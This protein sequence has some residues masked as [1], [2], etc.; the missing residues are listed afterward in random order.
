MELNLIDILILLIL[1]FI[2]LV[3][4]YNFVS[5]IQEFFLKVITN[6]IYVLSIIFQIVLVL[7]I[8]IFIWNNIKIFIPVEY[9]NKVE[10]TIETSF[11]YSFFE[12]LFIKWDNLVSIKKIFF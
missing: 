2:F 1:F 5:L 4:V 3:V 12:D 7:I 8:L 10:K 11:F 9:N 6:L